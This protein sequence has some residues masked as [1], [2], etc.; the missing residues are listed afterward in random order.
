MTNN[1]YLSQ[2]YFW[3]CPFSQW[4]PTSD[5]SSALVWRLLCVTLRQWC[6]AANWDRANRS[7]SSE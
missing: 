1:V 4:S 7:S 6:H 5:R 2:D 3:R